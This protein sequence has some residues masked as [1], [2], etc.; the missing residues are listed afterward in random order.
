MKRG[1][2]YLVV[3]S[4]LLL[5]TGSAIRIYEVN[6]EVKLPEKKYFSMNE[7]VEFGQ[8]FYKSK[9][10]MIDGY[11]IEVLGT[12]LLKARD[13]CEKY[14]LTDI[15]YIQDRNYY[16][17]VKT[18]IENENC[19]ESEEH[20]IGIA[21]LTLTGK[22][23][24]VISDLEMYNL[25]NPD[26][27]EGVGFSLSKGKAREVLIPYEIFPENITGNEKK[28]EKILRDNPPYLKITDYPTQKMIR[29]GM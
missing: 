17:I 26:M 13:F 25:I 21:N 10:E 12:E 18:K 2:K 9:E 28:I 14:H 5:V 22:N 7:K 3:L 29:T 24:I 19:P 16:Y 6:K 23:Y 27:P 4:G 8:D 15:E 11:T 1:W 20:G